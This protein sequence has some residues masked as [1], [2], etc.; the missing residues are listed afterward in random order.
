MNRCANI[1]F[2]GFVIVLL[3]MGI[4]LVDATFTGVCA[5]ADEPAVIAPEKAAFDPA[6]V[7]RVST[8]VEAL[9]AP[10]FQKRNSAMGELGAM[11]PGILPLL[12]K[13]TRHNNRE[14]RLRLGI[15]MRILREDDFQNRL[16]A[17][18]A[19]KE[20]Q[21]DEPMPFW[22]PYSQRVGDTPH[23]RALFVAI[24]RAEGPFLQQVHA[25]PASTGVLA[26]NRALS[27]QTS[28]NAQ[29]KQ[30]PFAS[31]ATLLLLGGISK[32][33]LAQ[34]AEAAIFGLCYQASLRQALADPQQ[35][36][37]ARKLLGAWI[38]RGKDWSAYQA[39]SL[40]LTHGLK[41][42]LKPAIRVLNEGP[43][44]VHIR[45]YAVLAIAKFGDKSHAPLLEKLLTDKTVCG[46]LRGAN[47]QII[48]CQIRDVALA[49]LL[50][51][52][53]ENPKTFGFPRYQPH[54]TTVFV[55][56]TAGFE[57]DEQ[58][59]A[60]QAKWRASKAARQPQ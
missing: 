5:L 29:G 60:I 24:L 12:K 14:V 48:A 51:L 1:R 32:Q 43:A 20:T 6:V 16:E 55:A 52:H 46:Q 33:P 19:G 27:L 4:V 3:F 34:Q 11:G 53:G 30:V 13:A 58:R 25:Q 42:G 26:S 7:Q 59:D 8:L 9:G 44:H 28:I 38:E 49:A 36:A 50:H 10:A 35:G 37:A 54:A 39:I 40:S 31:I 17:F 41:N 23:S 15:L 47:K 45:Q 2:S 57:T 56:T 18:A 21:H 22:E